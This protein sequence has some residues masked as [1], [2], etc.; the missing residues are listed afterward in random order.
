MSR[1]V[2]R[3]EP[4]LDAAEVPPA[5]AREYKNMSSE[6]SIVFDSDKPQSQW[7]KLREI[8]QYRYL[9]RN[10]VIRDLKVRYKNSILGV[11]WSLLTPLLMM[12]V[13]TLLFTK[14]RPTSRGI[15]DFHIFILV[16]LIPWRF[17][18]GSLSG[19]TQSVIGNAP[20]LKK[21]YFP[22]ILLPLSA[23]L[24][25]LVNFL[26]SWIIFVIILWLAGLQLTIHVLWFPFIL[27]TQIIFMAGLSLILGTLNAFYRD[28]S[29]VLEVVL[30]AWFFLTPIFYPFED[31]GTDTT[32]FGIMFNPA[33]VMRWLNPM[34]SIIDGYRT[35]LWGTIT[36]DG[37]ASMDPLNL[38][39]TFVTVFIIFIIGYMAFNRAEYLFSEKL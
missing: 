27:L 6:L 37:P 5:T 4:A 20:L 8:Y 25:H 33:R 3:Q 39:R 14:L 28:I 1:V 9:L 10:L 32:L 19:A 12:I 24:T 15:H 18:T 30:M 7:D 11:I 22:R 21:V 31:L 26:L 38:L 2:V 16:A 13:Y 29:M 35:I 36:S 23:I 17:L 34:A